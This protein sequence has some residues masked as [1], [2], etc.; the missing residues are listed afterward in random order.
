MAN[1]NIKP[2]TRFD[3]APF[4]SRK[5]PYRKRVYLPV[6]ISEKRSHGSIASNRKR[7]TRYCRRATD[8]T[9]GASSIL[10]MSLRSDAR[11]TEGNDR[12]AITEK[13]ILFFVTA[14]RQ[15]STWVDNDI[16]RASTTMDSRLLVSLRPSCSILFERERKTQI[17]R[18]TNE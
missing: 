3:V 17:G 16:T 14:E 18:T 6:N 9:L 12:S 2:R 5:I 1:R 7:G 4:R 15:R 11:M 10:R 8:T 13:K